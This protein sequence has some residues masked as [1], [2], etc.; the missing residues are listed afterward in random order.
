MD[1]PRSNM[2]LVILQTY[3]QK[4]AIISTLWSKVELMMMAK[5]FSDPHRDHHEFQE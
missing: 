2:E 1:Q 3:E 4:P 5:Y